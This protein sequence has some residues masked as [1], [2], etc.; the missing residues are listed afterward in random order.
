MKKNEKAFETYS[1]ALD[2][3]IEI[4][5]KLNIIACNNAIADYFS[6][7]ENYRKALD[8]YFVSNKRIKELNA[9]DKLANNLYKIGSTHRVRGDLDSAITYINL[10]IDIIRGLG[11]NFMV[12]PLYFDL[13]L[14][15]VIKGDIDTGLELFNRSKSLA[16]EINDSTY[17]AWYPE[18]F[19]FVNYKKNDFKSAAS[20]FENAIALLKNKDKEL[21]LLPNTVYFLCLRELNREYDLPKIRKLIEEE[22]EG[23]GW[24]DSYYVYKLLGER[25]Y[26]KDAYDKVTKLKSDLEPEVAEK[27]MN[28]PDVKEIIKEWKM[29]I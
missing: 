24:T 15:Y 20:E 13:G 11:N 4:D 10:A 16:E 14:Y 23:L 1:N 29:N 5:N 7:Q 22:G 9:P 3:S 12:V 19:G 21:D 18:M 27:F 6:D 25:L 26:L 17:V 28:I 8:Y 2:L